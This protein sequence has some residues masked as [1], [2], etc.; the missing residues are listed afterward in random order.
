[1]G[2]VGFEAVLDTAELK[3]KYKLQ[4]YIEQQ[5]QFFSCPITVEIGNN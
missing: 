4:I 1:M 2:A 5:K 3:G